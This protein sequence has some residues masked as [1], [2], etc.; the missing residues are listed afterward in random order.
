M[1][2]TAM[3]NSKIT[4]SAGKSLL[5]AQRTP[6]AVFP[7]KSTNR[8][9]RN[10]IKLLLSNVDSNTLQT[11]SKDKSRIVL[12]TFMIIGFPPGCVLRPNLRETL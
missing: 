11:A 6:L 5:F 7:R 12:N 10:G 3:R 2:I 9:V 8:T 4:T 1:D